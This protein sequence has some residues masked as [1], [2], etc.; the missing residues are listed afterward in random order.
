MNMKRNVIAVLSALVVFSVLSFSIR[1]SYGYAGERAYS[2]GKAES[3]SSASV[4]SSFSAAD[5]LGGQGMPGGGSGEERPDSVIRLISAEGSARMVEIDGKPFRKVIGPAVFLHNNTYLLCDSAI[6]DVNSEFLDALGNVRIIQANAQL[7]SD[8]LHYIVGR[9]LAQFRGSVVEL[10]DA[11]SNILRTTYLDYYTKDSVAEFFNG[12]AL[13]DKDGN[14][15]ESRKGV[16][17]SKLKL[18]TFSN[19]VKM[20]SGGM[21]ISSDSMK[22]QTE[23]DRVFFGTDT[24]I[25]NEDNFLSADDGLYDR[26]NEIIHFYDNCYILTPDQEIFSDSLNYY[27]FDESA[28]L[29]DNVQIHDRE[30]SVMMFGDYAYYKKE[31]F[32]AYLTENPA[33]AL[34][35]Y[36]DGVPDTLFMSADTMM[37]YNRLYRDVDSTEIVNAAERSKLNKIDAIAE[38]KKNRAAAAASAASG[39]SS[40]RPGSGMNRGGMPGQGSGPARQ[41]GNSPQNASDGP[42]A[43]ETPAADSLKAGQEGMDAASVKSKPEDKKKNKKKKLRKKRKSGRETVLQDS[44]QNALAKDSSS[45]S[46]QPGQA[47]PDSVSGNFADSLYS[48]DSLVQVLDS[49]VAADSLLRGTDS[50]PLAA[51]DSSFAADSLL[52]GGLQSDSLFVMDSVQM[53]KMQDS[54]RVADS[55][56]AAKLAQDTVKVTFVRAHHNV[57][58]FRSNIQG[59]ADSMIYTSLDSITRLYKSPVMWNGPSNQFSADSMQ[60]ITEGQSIKKAN[61]LGSSF[62]ISMEDT[63]YYNQIKS[64]EMTAYFNHNELVRFDALGGVSAI[65]FMKEED[66]ISTMNPKEAKMMSVTFE[67]NQFKRNLYIDAI[68]N[69]AISVIGLTPEKTKL[70]DFNWR[71]TERPDTRRA[72]TQRQVVKSRRSRNERIPYPEYEETNLYFDD[73]M[74][75]V[76][77][78]I[79][80]AKKQRDSARMAENAAKSDSEQAARDEEE[81]MAA[82]EKYQRDK[83]NIGRTIVADNRKSYFILYIEDKSEGKLTSIKMS[84][85]RMKYKEVIKE[86]KALRKE[87]EKFYKKVSKKGYS[88]FAD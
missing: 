64:T 29:Y 84:S 58:F 23:T 51:A 52:A 78:E 70:R 68:K 9:N 71:I 43:A 4:A 75:P 57:K 62:V 83:E 40:G 31:P 49:I 69:D 48:A 53:A 8:S 72:V 17:Q 80:I 79:L 28:D 66:V 46:L 16:Y 35:G 56:A 41:P 81:Q 36:D 5:S 11:D 24:K 37:I 26:M 38:A 27:R 87:E 86:M 73:Y 30:N 77:E 50:L 19:L 1:K 32:K 21:L 6:W 88:E 59:L 22:Y 2:I 10:H 39:N 54:I 76:M 25:W 55:I 42:S 14:V 15:I 67:N 3:D 12:G 20:Y 74:V 60:I 44:V 85:M 33:F 65:F 82:A 18:F 13:V 34:Y 7:W 61:L 47:F 45:Y 63:S